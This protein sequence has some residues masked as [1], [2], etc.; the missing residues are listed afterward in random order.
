MNIK[1][2][3][4]LGPKEGHVCGR[5]E[6]DRN[7]GAKCK[8]FK[9]QQSSIIKAFP[10]SQFPLNSHKLSCHVMLSNVPIP[11]QFLPEKAS[12]STLP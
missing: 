7:G 6:R 3:E 10:V 1:D 5:R 12:S 2:S 8:K 11:T 4:N 9:E